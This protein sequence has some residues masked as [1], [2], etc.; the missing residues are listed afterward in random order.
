MAVGTKCEHLYITHTHQ[1]APTTEEI[2]NNQVG[3]MT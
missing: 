1:K 2:L 3:K